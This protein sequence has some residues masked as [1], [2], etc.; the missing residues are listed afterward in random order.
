VEGY[1]SPRSAWVSALRG[2]LVR[3][4]RKG[5]RLFTGLLVRPEP[6]TWLRL[7]SAANRRNTLFEVGEQLV[8]DDGAWVPLV[9]E[10]AFRPGCP[11]T[12]RLE[13]ELACLGPLRPGVRFEA[14]GPGAT[15]D[16][17]R[18]HAAFYDREYFEAKREDVT[19][20]YR[21]LVSAEPVDVATAAGSTAGD[22][23]A[24]GATAGG[25]TAGGTRASGAT[26]GVATAECRLASIGPSR[27]AVEALDR[28]TTA[29]GPTP[30]RRPSEARRL[31]TVVF[32]NEV[33][34]RALF[35]GHTLA[36]DYDRARL[37]AQARAVETGFREA[38]AG[39]PALD[40]PGSL[41]YLTKY[42]TPHPP[43]EPHFFVK[44]WALTA[45]PPG[46]SSL[47]E[48]AHGEGYD[49]MRGIVSTDVFHA[50]PAV[51][52]IHREGAWVRVAEDAP[53]VRVI[54][55]PRALLGR[56]VRLRRLA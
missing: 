21:R 40:H 52:R 24:G 2:P 5:L 54:P 38:L 35:D 30:E 51:F 27:H 26:A 55:L 56:E 17:L 32:R 43:G 4:T 11:A 47:V 29:A 23:I 12:F 53:L 45:T 15:R 44:P 50:T 41:L 16:L 22:G 18:A 9:L 8:A 31:E 42:F 6:G 48:G 7:T 1:L 37:G 46:W 10:L 39:S 34:F 36:L 33:A 20:K 14:P 3:S 28:F 13:G 25:G 49:V 19:G